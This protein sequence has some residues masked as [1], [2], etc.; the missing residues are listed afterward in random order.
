MSLPGYDAW[1]LASPPEYD[2]PDTCE[3]C[4]A[5]CDDDWS[6]CPACGYGESDEPDRDDATEAEAERGHGT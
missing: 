2:M 3:K 5:Q 1:K 6:Q 4:G